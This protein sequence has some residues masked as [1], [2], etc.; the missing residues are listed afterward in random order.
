MRSPLK[1]FATVLAC[2]CIPTALG[3]VRIHY[4]RAVEN[5]PL[6]APVKVV[7]V[8]D[9]RLTL[10]DGRV[11]RVDVFGESL[12]GLVAAS[13]D[14]VDL[15]V[16]GDGRHAEVFAKHRGWICGTPWVGII[17]VPLIPVNV[18]INRRQCIGR[19]ELVSSEDGAELESRL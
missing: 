14:R 3:I 2:V 9:D 18:S 11:F 15:E 13:N 7:Q 17:N 6:R 10:S 4:P 5:D 8:D 12:A 16:N 19:G 1:T